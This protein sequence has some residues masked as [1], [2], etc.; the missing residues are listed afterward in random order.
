[1]RFDSIIDSISEWPLLPIKWT[2]GSEK[3]SVRVL[4]VLLF[5]PWFFLGVLIWVIITGIL[6]LPAMIQDA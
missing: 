2:E 1:M 4:G 5:C 3:K 6:A